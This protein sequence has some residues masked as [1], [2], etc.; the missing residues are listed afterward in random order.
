MSWIKCRILIACKRNKRNRNNSILCQS[1]KAYYK[2]WKAWKS[3]EFGGK[4][5]QSSTEYNSSDGSD[6]S[7]FTLHFSLAPRLRDEFAI[8][9]MPSGSPFASIAPRTKQTSIWR[10]IPRLDHNCP[11]SPQAIKTPFIAMIWT[12]SESL[13]KYF[14]SCQ[15][16]KYLL[17]KDEI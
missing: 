14:V 3:L 13:S 2:A 6:M 15:K 11:L 8:G 10:Q 9:V 12:W 5:C 4:S 1:W 17:N 7:W 16:F